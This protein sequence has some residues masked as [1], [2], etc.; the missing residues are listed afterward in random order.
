MD[1]VRDG[2]SKDLPETM[3]DEITA[4]EHDITARTQQIELLTKRLEG[5]K[6]ATRTIP[7]GSSCDHRVVA[8]QHRR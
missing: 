1:S 2:F 8:H 6:R 3:Q 4:V 5:L 7:F